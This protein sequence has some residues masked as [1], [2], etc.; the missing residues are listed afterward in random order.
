MA[1]MMM[2]AICYRISNYFLIFIENKVW[3][4]KINSNFYTHFITF[5][6]GEQNVAAIFSN[7]IVCSQCSMALSNLHKG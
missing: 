5:H 3:A 4:V 1:I 6:I 2:I 7:V